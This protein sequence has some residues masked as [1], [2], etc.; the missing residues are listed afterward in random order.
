[1]GNSDEDLSLSDPATIRQVNRKRGELREISPRGVGF[2]SHPRLQSM[3]R[4]R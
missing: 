1:M 3:N 4:A 2:N